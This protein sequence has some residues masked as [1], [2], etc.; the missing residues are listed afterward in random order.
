M[1]CDSP[2]E[3]RVRI[4]SILGECVRCALDLKEILVE[5]RKAL[6]DRD[7]KS[8]NT[9]ANSKLALVREITDLNQ[10]RDK[11]SAQ[12]GFGNSPENMEDLT[13]W[14][15]DDRVV[16]KLWQKLQRIAI[17]CYLMNRTNGAIIH[18]RHQQTL[19]GLSV[20]RGSEN[21]AGTYAPAGSA[22]NNFTARTIVEA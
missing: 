7:T 20:L 6:Q 15:D 13:D 4:T 2:E 8:L 22:T 11:V 9:A 14:C 21:D 16:T 12:A 1:K 18:L 10:T 19:N 3:T 17:E 5:E